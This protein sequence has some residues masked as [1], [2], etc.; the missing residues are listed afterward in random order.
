M[1]FNSLEFLAFFPVVVLLHFALPARWRWLLLLAA[2]Y[3]FYAAWKAEYLGLI[4][5][6]TAV[7]YGV[8]LAIGASAGLLRRR[9]FLG[10]SL[11]VNLGL[12][13]TFKYFDFLA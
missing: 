8:A 5:I 9:L 11:L 10:L 12:L 3:L 13:A 7:D 6:S 4:L 1:A 2:S